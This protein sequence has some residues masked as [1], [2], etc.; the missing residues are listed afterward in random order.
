MF[1]VKKLFSRIRLSLEAKSRGEVY[2]KRLM[3]ETD[4]S[5]PDHICKPFVNTWR[6]Q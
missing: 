4:E 3:L 2:V 1:F 5:S 6:L